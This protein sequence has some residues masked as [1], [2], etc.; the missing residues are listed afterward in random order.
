[1]PIIILAVLGLA[2]MMC[3]LPFSG[4][5]DQQNLSATIEALQAELESFQ[6]TASPGQG[7]QPDQAQEQQPTQPRGD[8]SGAMIED[9]FELDLGTFP[10]GEG[11][12]VTDQ[13]Y[14][15]GPFEQCA[16]DVGNFD[17]PVGCNAVCETCGANL[18]NFHF[19][20][21]FS[22]EE[23]LSDRSFG[24]ILRFVDKDNDTMLDYE[25]YLL[26]LG[27][28]IAT[29]QFSVYLH[30]P[31][32]IDPWSVVKSGQA[33]LLSPGRMNRIEITT[34]NKGRLMDV[35]LNQARI[36]ILTADPPQP[37]ETLVTE[38]AD[39]GAVGFLVLGR[40]VQARFDNFSF[41]PLP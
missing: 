30:T 23:G 6:A 3:T 33:G 25:D 10:L 39:S 17:N 2:T 4:D 37:G 1:V 36:V 22:F 14:L 5:S 26:S 7:N 27:F 15:L 34:S 12:Q 31:D 11:M 24:L 13:A 29:N 21:H 19:N 9:T 35:F 32:R 20:V 40:G 38:W 18:R 28:N 16:N 41:E 8:S